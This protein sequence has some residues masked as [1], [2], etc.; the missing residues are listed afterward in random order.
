MVSAFGNICVFADEKEMALMKPKKPKKCRNPACRSEFTP[1]RPMQ[2]V[3]GYACGLALV[4]AKQ[5]K[6]GKKQAKA[7][8]AEIREAK[9]KLKRRADYMR[10]AQASF[11][12]YI[13]ERDAHLPCIS[14]GRHHDGQYHAGHYRTTAAS[15]ELRFNELNVH[16]QCAP[17]NNHKSG[18]IVN[19]RINLA[20]K[21]GAENVEW[22]EGPHDPAKYSI[23][24]LQQIKTTYR[25][26]TRELRRERECPGNASS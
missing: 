6:E 7:E 22:L 1:E 8:R 25:A 17:C 26:K 13:R 20:A 9:Q 11:N 19:Y 2:T 16:K 14:C 4:K 3:C 12:E 5:E 23:E 24:E 10:E 21:I 18:D 15:P